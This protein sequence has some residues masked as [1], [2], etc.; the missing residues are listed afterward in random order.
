MCSRFLQDTTCYKERRGGKFSHYAESFSAEQN[1][2]PFLL[3]L[4]RTWDLDIQEPESAILFIDKHVFFCKSTHV[5]RGE[6][7]GRHY[8]YLSLEFSIHCEEQIIKR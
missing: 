5:R 4:T 1:Y 2:S 7:R 3:K 8:R 6:E